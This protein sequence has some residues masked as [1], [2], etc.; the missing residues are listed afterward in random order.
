M[1]FISERSIKATRKRHHCV[2]CDKWIEIGEAAVNWA[3]VT[4]GDFGSVHYHPDCR[5]AE[6]AFNALRDS[7]YD[8]WDSLR[9]IDHEDY[10]WLKAEY[11]VVYRR[12]MMTRE[13]YAASLQPTERQS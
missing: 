7:Y 6:I 13:Q 4:D 11:P 3:G 10:R 2:A 1:G 5:E 8:E 9:D 12:R